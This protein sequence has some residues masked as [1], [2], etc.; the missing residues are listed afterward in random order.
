MSIN[1]VKSLSLILI[2]LSL[3]FKVDFRLQTELECCSDDHDYYI[4]AETIVTDLDFDYSNQLEGFEGSRN[5]INGKSAPIGFYGTGALSTPFMYIGT[6]IDKFSNHD[7]K[8]G[9]SFKLLLYS[10]S[11][12][13]YFLLTFLILI[14]INKEL[15]INYSKTKLLL[16]FLGT[17]LPY[18]VFE[19]YSMTH[20]FDTFS[21]TCLIYSIILFYKYGSSKYLYII[22]FLS[23]LTLTIRWTNYQI[24]LLPLIIQKLFFKESKYRIKDNIFKVLAP[25]LLLLCLFLIHSKLIWGIYTLNPRD[26]YNQHEFV[27][28]FFQT[29]IDSP[30]NFLFSNVEDIFITLSTMEFGVMWFSPIIFIGLIISLKIIREDTIL[31]IALILVY[32]FYFIIINIWQSVGNAYGI[33]YLY[34]LISISILLFLKNYNKN[35]IYSRMTEYYV[36][37]F[38]T[39]SLLSV[40]FFES[41]EG[42]QLS[43]VAIENSFG[44]YEKFVQPNYLP[45]FLRGLFEI[46]SYLKVFT[47]SF[48]GLIFFRIFL[49]L[50]DKDVLFSTLEKLDL[51]SS[52][53]DFIE[54]IYQISRINLLAIFVIIIFLYLYAYFLNKLLKISQS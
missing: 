24:F 47:T 4:H 16:L 19:R 26:I 18:Y 38:S 36:F 53:S 41:W 52:N 49:W 8:L 23:F 10:F 12:P 31:S 22:S 6:L 45:G 14:K 15:S 48:L 11:S 35:N 39:L 5:F 54:Y 30:L 2:F 28:I 20:V 17:G 40:L 37:I 3:F 34:P 1:K 33:R 29:A 21:I 50:Y 44:K 46:D 9:Y 32:G 27:S 43:L 25:S 51:P 42:S 7:F 13:F